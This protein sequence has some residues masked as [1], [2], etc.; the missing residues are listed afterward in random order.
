[1]KERI[2]EASTAPQPL[3]FELQ[4]IGRLSVLVAEVRRECDGGLP[5]DFDLHLED[6][7][8][9]LGLDDAAILRILD[10]EQLPS[11]APL[12]LVLA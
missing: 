2:I 11:E 10:R 8:R 3:L 9:A 5:A 1:M 4:I 6:I 12:Q 7:A